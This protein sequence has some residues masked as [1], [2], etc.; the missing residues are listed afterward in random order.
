MLFAF[1]DYGNSAVLLGSYGVMLIV[2]LKMIR[3]LGNQ[4]VI[5]S[6]TRKRM[7]NL[8]K[9]IALQATIPLVTAVPGTESSEYVG[10]LNSLSSSRDLIFNGSFSHHPVVTI[11]QNQVPTVPS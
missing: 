4:N 7:L 11:N 3:F 5:M 6:Q 2:G 8:T 9:V 10:Q 1:A